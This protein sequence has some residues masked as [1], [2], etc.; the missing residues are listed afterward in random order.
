MHLFNVKGRINHNK[1]IH[2]SEQSTCIHVYPAWYKNHFKALR[3]GSH[4][5]IC[6]EHQAC[7]YLVSIHQTAPPQIDS[8]IIYRPRE[9]EKLSWPGWLTSSGRFTHLS[10][11]PSAEVK[12]ATGKI[13][14]PRPM[15]LTLCHATNQHITHIIHFSALTTQAEK[16]KRIWSTKSPSVIS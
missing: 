12:R 8:L 2:K 11:H 7:L 13:R 5:L 9:D 4:S 1:I 15:F 3:H 10:S 16:Q 14:R 6:K